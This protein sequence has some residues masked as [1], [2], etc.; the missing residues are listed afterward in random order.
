MMGIRLQENA[1]EARGKLVV[2]MTIGF[3]VASMVSSAAAPQFTDFIGT[4]QLQIDR[5]NFFILELEGS[6]PAP[7]GTFWRPKG[8]EV[9]SNVFQVSDPHAAKYVL[10]QSEIKDGDLRL[11]FRDVSKDETEFNVRSQGDKIELSIPEVPREAGLGPWT[12]ESA[13]KGS[14]ISESWQPGRA[15]MVGDDDVSNAEIDEIYA[16][17]QADR[18]TKSID[19]QKLVAND[20]V[21]LARTKEMIEQGLLHT[22]R[23]Y[24]QAAFILQHGSTPNDYLMAHSLAVVAISKGEPTALWIASASL[25][26]F[27]WSKNLPQVFGTQSHTSDIGASTPEPY[28]VQAIPS[29]LK[30][31]LGVPQK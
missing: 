23:D 14:A 13:P 20:R 4:W 3:L 8:L 18:T 19:M 12:L 24:K 5:Q 1:H 9:T 31:Q 28:D 11:T 21:R 2:S 26:R 15:Y 29:R 16:Q 6:N 7:H 30:S 25:D 10:V 22:G 17:D 27:L